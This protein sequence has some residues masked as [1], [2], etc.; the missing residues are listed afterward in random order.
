MATDQDPQLCDIEANL[1][2]IAR[3]RRRGDKT[4]RAVVTLADPLA[5]WLGRHFTPG[6]LQVAGTAIVAAAAA[7]AHLE[8]E[9]MRNPAAIINILGVAGAHLVTDG[10]AWAEV[11]TGA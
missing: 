9:G 5:D 6:E 2:E 10:R 1:G 8:S 7:I 4:A 3:F 11:H